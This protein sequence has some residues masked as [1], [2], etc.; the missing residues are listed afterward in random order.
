MGILWVGHVQEQVQGSVRPVPGREFTFRNQSGTPP[1]SVASLRSP[2][3]KLYLASAVHCRLK[4]DNSQFP[5]R[6]ISGWSPQGW[7]IN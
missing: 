7:P 4:F 2:T 5:A 3:P 1:T 6:L